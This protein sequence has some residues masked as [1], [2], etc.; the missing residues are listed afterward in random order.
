MNTML[1]QKKELLPPATNLYQYMRDLKM[2]AKNNEEH[3]AY[4]LQFDKAHVKKIFAS[5]LHVEALAAMLKVMNCQDAAFFKE[6][7]EKF[8]I[9]FIEGI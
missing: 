3:I 7:A 4:L 5:D 9:P 8:V 6:H 1:T 2:L